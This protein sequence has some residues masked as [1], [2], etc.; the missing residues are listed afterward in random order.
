MTLRGETMQNIFHGKLD[1][2]RILSYIFSTIGLLLFLLTLYQ[3]SLLK[4]NAEGL[5]KMEYISSEVQRLTKL[6]LEN[7]HEEALIAILDTA[8]NELIPNDNN[9][10]YFK[11]SQ[12]INS[13]IMNFVNSW[14]N[15]KT[16]LETYNNNYDRDALFIASEIIYINSAREIE[17][18]DEYIRNFTSVSKRI[19]LILIIDTVIIIILFIKIL[20]KT[21]EELEKNKELSKDMFIDMSTG[22]YNS[23]KCHE[24]L[25]KP[26]DAQN[27]KERA[28]AIFDLNDL[29][30]T[31]DSLGHRAGDLL[32]Y[33]F[34]EQLKNATKTFPFDIFVGRYGGDEFMV[35]FDFVSEEEVQLYIKEVENLIK[36]FNDTQGKPFRLSCAVGYAITTKESKSLTM[37]ELFDIADNNMYVNKL[38]MKQRIK[39]EL[40][41]KNLQQESKNEEYKHNE[42][43]EENP[44]HS[45]K[46]P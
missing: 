26:A 22:L 15:F 39:Q 34:A 9:K 35:S 29:K 5:A 17:T 31:N 1:T 7:N 14:R 19:D 21:N 46:L 20:V 28:I 43:N 16:S 27:K 10:T 25:K 24:V 36:V 4:S 41:E 2:T 3:D 40:Y 12:N 13:S 42:P 45:E 6:E 44:Q 33:S 37:R 8:V 18:V 30:K 32:I 23:S 11:E 38:A